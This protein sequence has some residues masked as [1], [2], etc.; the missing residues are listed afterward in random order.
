LSYEVKRETN[1]SRA[2]AS[3]SPNACYGIKES[4]MADQKK[5]AHAACTCM[6]NEKY[7]SKFCEDHKDTTE[8]AC[9]CGHPGCKGDIA[10]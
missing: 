2:G 8:I 1:D 6:T 3:K 9:D 5:C 4:W 10:S 7:C